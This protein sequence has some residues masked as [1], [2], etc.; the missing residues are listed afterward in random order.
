M[1][2]GKIAIE[3]TNRCNLKCQ[4]CFSGRHGGSDDLELQLLQNVL[5]EAK[6][7]G[8][9]HIGYT[10]GD[11]TVHPHFEEVL[12]ITFE[13]GYEFGFITNGW[14]FSTIYPRLLPYRSQLKIITFSLEGPT[15][16][17]HDLLRGT[18]SYRRVMKAMS[19][20]VALDLPF[21]INTVITA[22]N[23]HQL[24]EMVPLAAQLG[25][26][27]LRFAHLMPSPKTTF[28]G[29]DLSPWERKV[30]ESEVWGLQRKS[31]IKIAFAP[32][33]HTTSLFPCAP[34][35]MEEV[36]VDCHGNVTKCCHLSGHGEGVGQE[37][38]MGN[39]KHVSFTDA[40]QRLVT[41]NGEF[42]QKKLKRLSSGSFQDS[43]FFP[44][45]YCSLYYQKVEWLK[46]VNDHPWSSLMWKRGSRVEGGKSPSGTIPLTETT[47][48]HVEA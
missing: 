30:V 41:E 2:M 8:F 1:K 31:P 5:D 36:N 21:T 4:H 14:N 39:L 10:G 3:L 45:W 47:P 6:A 29:F 28:Q 48:A 19:V 15:E 37:D 38:V 9:N 20:C 16:E 24:T 25:A 40:Y 12:R 23:R 13:A 18:G 17:T 7:C 43:D 26:R 33:Y 11:P 34:L 32:G 35:Q 27:G 44:C 22:H 46:K 42:H